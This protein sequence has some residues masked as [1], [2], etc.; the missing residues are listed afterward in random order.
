MNVRD[1]RAFL[2]RFGDDDWV[3]VIGSTGRIIVRGNGMEVALIDESPAS[4]EWR[5]PGMIVSVSLQ[6]WLDDTREGR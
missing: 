5:K 2:T 6:H 3:E 4:V 1:V